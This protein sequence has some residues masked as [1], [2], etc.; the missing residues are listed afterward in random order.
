MVAKFLKNVEI[1]D[2]MRKMRINEGETLSVAS[3]NKQFYE[4]RKEN[5]WET[6]VPKSGEGDIYEI[7]ED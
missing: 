5:G 3:Q 4:L 2:G 7:L 6:M 1:A